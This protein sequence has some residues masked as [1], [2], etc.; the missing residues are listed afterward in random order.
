M[1]T[2]SVTLLMDIEWFPVW[3]HYKYCCVNIPVHDFWYICTHS[4]L[5]L[6]IRVELRAQGICL[7]SISS[8]NASKVSGYTNLHPQYQC[9]KILISPNPLHLLVS[10]VTFNFT[11]CGGNAVMFYAVSNLYF[12][13]DL[14]S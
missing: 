14:R 9:R 6:C 4:S 8:A 13:A 1:G 2:R 12:P 7:C 11:H 3:G 5:N 10:K